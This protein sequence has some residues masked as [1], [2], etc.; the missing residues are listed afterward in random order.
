MFHRESLEEL[1]AKLE[2]IDAEMAAHPLAS[3]RV[4]AAH[5]LVEMKGDK[6]T[7]AVSRELADQNLPSLEEIQAR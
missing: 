2:T 6:D 7:E 4:K 1:E 5:A 3:K